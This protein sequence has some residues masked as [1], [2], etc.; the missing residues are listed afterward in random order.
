MSGKYTLPSLLSNKVLEAMT[1]EELAQ[2]SAKYTSVK[3]KFIAEYRTKQEKL[4]ALIAKKQKEEQ[5]E[6]IKNDPEYFSK[7]QGVGGIVRYPWQKEMVNQIQQ[8][9]RIILKK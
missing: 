2:L 9:D 6:R 5:E 1:S 7:L 4:H 3:E 8:S